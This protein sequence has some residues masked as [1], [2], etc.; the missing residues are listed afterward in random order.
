MLSFFHLV[1]KIPADLILVFIA[2]L[3]YL[4]VLQIN[5]IWDLS[6]FFVNKIRCGISRFDEYLLFPSNT[7]LPIDICIGFR[8]WV[9]TDVSWPESLNTSKVEERVRPWGFWLWP[10]G[11]TICLGGNISWIWGSEAF[12][13]DLLNSVVTVVVHA[14]VGAMPEVAIP[15]PLVLLIGEPCVSQDDGYVRI[16]G[17]GAGRPRLGERCSFNYV[18]EAVGETL[19]LG[20]R[21]L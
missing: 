14:W 3:D 10:Q 13:E 20:G 5:Q 15:G 11:V 12:W 7:V 17:F 4:Y 16:H 8:R 18:K 19:T 2:W 6:T 9:G 1:H 21:I